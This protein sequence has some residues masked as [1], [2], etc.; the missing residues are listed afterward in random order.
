MLDKIRYTITVYNDGPCNATNV[1]VSEVLSSHLKLIKNET[2][3]G[4][5]DVNKGINV[6]VVTQ[7]C[8]VEGLSQNPVDAADEAL[9]TKVPDFN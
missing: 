9:G 7:G 4:Y 5:Y 6:Y 8:Q 2:D 3:Y 1:N